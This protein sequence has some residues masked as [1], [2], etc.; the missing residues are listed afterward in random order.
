MSSVPRP[1]VH[2]HA[3]RARA[4]APTVSLLRLSAGIRLAGVA[5]L[6]V[7]MW[8]AILATIRVI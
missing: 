6:I 8:L 3:P 5:V 2:D 7:L 4:S 1:P